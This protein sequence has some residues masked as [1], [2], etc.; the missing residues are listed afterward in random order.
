MRIFRPLIMALAAIIV[1]GCATS[2]LPAGILEFVVPAGRFQVST[3]EEWVQTPELGGYNAVESRDLD[4]VFGV[5]SVDPSSEEIATY[6]NPRDYEVNGRRITVYDGPSGHLPNQYFGIEYY[7]E[8]I[9]HA[10]VGIGA[11]RYHTVLIVSSTASQRDGYDQLLI[12]LASSLV[13][14]P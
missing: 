10:V 4:L 1:V 11:H 12:A 3:P 7:P 13:P 14:L 5:L 2:N 8:E 9:V 6:R